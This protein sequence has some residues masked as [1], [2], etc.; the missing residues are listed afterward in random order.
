M[1]AKQTQ[2]KPKV[3]FSAIY[4]GEYGPTVTVKGT[5]VKRA[6]YSYISRGIGVDCR[7]GLRRNYRLTVQ[8]NGSYTVAIDGLEPI[9]FEVSHTNEA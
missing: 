9:T 5:D 7:R 4:D 1:T 2:D 8:T 6:A 3:T